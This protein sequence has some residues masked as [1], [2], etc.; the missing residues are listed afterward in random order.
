[1]WLE[2]LQRK[3]ITFNIPNIT[4]YWVLKD[5]LQHTRINQTSM[6]QAMINWQNCSKEGVQQKMV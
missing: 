5:D 2:D 6:S 4:R 1:M 3:F